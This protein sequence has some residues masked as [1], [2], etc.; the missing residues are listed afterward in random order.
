VGGRKRRKRLVTA[1]HSPP[2]G[3]V[4]LRSFRG[5]GI[6]HFFRRSVWSVLF[7]LTK[8]WISTSCPV[9][10]F[11]TTPTVT[12]DLL[13]LPHSINL[14]CSVP[15]G[16]AHNKLLLSRHVPLHLACDPVWLNIKSGGESGMR[17]G[18]RTKGSRR[19]LSKHG[20][21]IDWIL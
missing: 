18:E 7:S 15:K 12:D 2:S 16:T 20:D 6:T 3:S 1:A 11:P 21:Q 8:L 4:T 14:Y 10:P 9:T 5:R 19:R 17:L 13:V